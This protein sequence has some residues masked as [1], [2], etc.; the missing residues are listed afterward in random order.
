MA[1]GIS[2]GRLGQLTASNLP[3]PSS[4]PVSVAVPGVAGAAM[5]WEYA[6]MWRT[7]PNLHTATRLLS[8]NVAELGLH[9][10]RRVSDEERRRERDHP[11]SQLLDRP[12]PGLTGYRLIERIVTDLSIF[13]ACYLLKG[14]TGDGMAMLVPLPCDW[15][16]VLGD[17]A[18][19]PAGYR[20]PS[21]SGNLDV[22]PGDM[23]AIHGYNPHDLRLGSSP[24]EALRDLLTEEA[25]ATRFRSQ[26]WRNGARMTGFITRPMDAPEWSDKARERFVESWRAYQRDGGKSGGTPLLEDGMQYQ[27]ASFNPQQAQYLEAR[28]LTREEIASAFFI[29]PPMLGILDNANYANVREMHKQLYQDTLGPIMRVIEQEIRAQVLP[30]LTDTEGIYVEFNVADKLKG[31]F[32]EQA[33]ALQTAVGRPWM[34]AAE[35]RAR[36]NLPP[37]DGADEL[38]TP[39]NVIVGEQASPNDTAPDE[40]NGPGKQSLPTTKAGDGAPGGEL[41]TRDTERDAFA[42]RL[43]ALLERDADRLAGE[44]TG[45]RGTAEPDWGQL[46]KLIAGCAHRLA[47]VGAESVLS[48]FNPDRSG[49]SA[50]VMWGWLRTAAAS[51]A[52]GIAYSLR[53]ALDEAAPAADWPAARDATLRRWAGR[54]GMWATTIATESVSFGGTDAAGV[55]G[56]G[57]KTW[58]A[59]ETR[60]EAL[61]GE[62]VGLDALF[63]NGL[64]W[65]A[66]PAGAPEQIAG[67]VCELTY[68]GRE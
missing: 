52:D 43:G 19:F 2:S 8:R 47:R 58:R 46:V 4:S 62:T 34:T 44:L 29:P 65:P 9:V 5:P 50:E 35:A 32:E 25:E 42:D 15:V 31:S 57:W 21:P 16:Q 67:C 60:H 7:Q 24:M 37:V 64:R 20:V 36:M 27:S 11:L 3:V 45:P 6:H 17:N 38:V 66:D 51:H 33:Q 41:G 54:A 68:T 26:M 1:F 61:N 39:L 14:R 40:T 48:R 28:K 13:D 56:V 63:S 22:A 49:W 18:F 23:V 30:D 10:F 55:S 12:M 53:K 59:R